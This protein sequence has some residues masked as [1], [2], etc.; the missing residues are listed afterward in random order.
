MAAGPTA[1][2][3]AAR[4]SAQK[5]TTA[6]LPLLAP[7]DRLASDTRERFV[8]AETL[9]RTFDEAVQAHGEGRLEEAEA[10]FRALSSAESCC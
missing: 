7:A 3:V 5:I 9:Q 6:I 2:K 4:P 8:D 10:G 1:R